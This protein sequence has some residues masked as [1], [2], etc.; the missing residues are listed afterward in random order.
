M[1]FAA[2]SSQLETESADEFRE[3]DQFTCIDWPKKV[4]YLIKKLLLSIVRRVKERLY[5]VQNRSV[6]HT[7]YICLEMLAFPNIIKVAEW[8]IV[9]PIVGKN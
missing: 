1:R 4:R 6:C 5:G 2:R 8:T 3:Q 7:K 9:I